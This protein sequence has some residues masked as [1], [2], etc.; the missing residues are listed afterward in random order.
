M[1]RSNKETVELGELIRRSE[2]SRLQL[3]QSHA[4]L[5]RKLD[6]PSKI[7]KSIKLNPLPWVGG[8]IATGFFGSLSLGK[9]K[10]KFKESKTTRKISKGFVIGSLS[11]IIKALKPFAKIY[12]TS[13][14]KDYLRNQLIRGAAARGDASR[15]PSY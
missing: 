4:V 14:L 12:V 6:I 13:L 7:K 3:S 8:S 10:K 11:L 15:R 9:K 2:A 1:A 5:K